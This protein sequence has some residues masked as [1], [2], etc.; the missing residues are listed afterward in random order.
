[1]ESG[2]SFSGGGTEYPLFR[3]APIYLKCCFI[4]EQ[5]PHYISRDVKHKIEWII[6]LH[7]R[8]V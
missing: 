7:R 3:Q 5:R 2:L 6:H 8:D 1:M 4:Y